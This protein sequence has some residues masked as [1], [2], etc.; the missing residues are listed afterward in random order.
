MARPK[1][2]EF[3]PR[4]VEFRQHSQLTQEQVADQIGITPEMVR[5]H[6][7]GLSLPVERYRQ[8]YCQLYDA[9]EEQLGFRPARSGPDLLVAPGVIEPASAPEEVV[10]ILTRVQKLEAGAGIEVIRCLDMTIGDFVIRYERVG[11]AS[12]TPVLTRQRQYLERLIDDCCQPAQRKQLFRLAGQTSGLLAYMAVNRGRFPLA[13]AYCT[14]AFQL[15]TFAE[16]PNLQAW[17]RGTQSFCEYYAG[18]YESSRDLARDGQ[19]YAGTGSQCVRLVINGEA[20][21]L[22]KLHDAN[23]VHRAV[24][25]ANNLMAASA[26]VPDEFSP[27]ISFG[28]YS[29]GRAASNAITAYVDLGLPDQIEM[30]AQVALPEFEASESQWSK[31]L[32]RLDMANSVALAK[33]A[34]RT[35][36]VHWPKKPLPSRRITRL[37]P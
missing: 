2:P 28:G 32:I 31:S 26:D 9:T 20:R 5:R 17:V 13:R 33:M 15:G 3:H 6:E 24:E 36:Q 7:H 34:I 27:C 4:L 11:P 35:R 19:Q 14:E 29:R 21:A 25:R 1:R 23:G 37:L 10:D 12:L 30:H 16:D 18:D 22:G 8:G